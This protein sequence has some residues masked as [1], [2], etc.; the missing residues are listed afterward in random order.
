MV[1]YSLIPLI[2]AQI[3]GNYNTSQRYARGHKRPESW[4]WLIKG[5]DPLTGHFV[6]NISKKGNNMHIREINLN[7]ILIRSRF[8]M[9]LLYYLL[10][11]PLLIFI[12]TSLFFFFLNITM[13]DTFSLNPIT[14]WQSF[15]LL[16]MALILFN[17]FKY[18]SG[19]LGLLSMLH[20]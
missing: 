12:I 2:V 4:L 16:L 8:Y 7:G 11:I 1:Q 5:P 17:G 19:L 6:K 14:F 13:P 9:A 20:L 18:L 3:A 15:R 10:L